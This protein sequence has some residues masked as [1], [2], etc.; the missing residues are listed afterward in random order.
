MRTRSANTTKEAKAAKAAK[1]EEERR[2]R[3]A[4]ARAEKVEQAAK[5]QEQA[6][7][8]AVMDRIV[9]KLDGPVEELDAELA[10]L[11]PPGSAGVLA[12]LQR[13]HHY[14]VYEACIRGLCSAIP[15]L[16]RALGDA[17]DVARAV[18]V[19]PKLYKL[20]MNF[21]K[22][23]F[24][25][26]FKAPILRALM[27]LYRCYGAHARI[28][29]EQ[30]VAGLA[31]FVRTPDIMCTVLS[32]CGEPG[33]ADVFE[34][35]AAYDHSMFLKV[36]EMSPA[37][38][39]CTMLAAYDGDAGSAALQAALTAQNYK[40]LRA[41]CS[42][43]NTDVLGIVLSKY[44]P[45]GNATIL[46][47]LAAYGH[48]ALQYAFKNADIAA[49]IL[50]SYGP[51]GCPAVL[52]ALSKHMS[53]YHNFTLLEF[54]VSS[55]PIIISPY[56]DAKLL[57]VLLTAYGP[58]GC[59]GIRATFCTPSCDI[60]S[61][62]IINVMFHPERELCLAMI[63]DA[64]AEPDNATALNAVRSLHKINLI[65]K[66]RTNS[67]LALLA[68]QS[69]S[70]W[71]SVGERQMLT[72]VPPEI[73]EALAMP[74]LL[75]VRRMPIGVAEPLWAYLRAHPWHLFTCNQWKVAF[76][77]L[78]GVSTSSEVV[79]PNGGTGLNDGST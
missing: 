34:V 24:Y 35:F 30:L 29:L 5:R 41:A 50:A 43:R 46:A 56:C 23:Y 1:L 60:L 67:I 12:V 63:L 40:A 71:A 10:A 32:A 70:I 42:N 28:D 13:R 52:D 6:R 51:P 73:R 74:M 62:T 4:A 17:P 27:L 55:D 8:K 37:D 3:A 7:L 21:K 59:A 65:K 15:S 66:L 44:G 39:V 53:L 9:E 31:P 49:M 26:P 14:V 2:A 76:D 54:F 16:V 45:P 58:T 79:V 36:L 18:L 61:R 78:S 33:S 47:A 11:G 72:L 22:T 38:V 25:I 75:T 68:L 64:I 48:K 77:T 20:R 69:S 19:S 57:S